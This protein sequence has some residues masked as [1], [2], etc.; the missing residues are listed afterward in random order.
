MQGFSTKL[1]DT[2]FWYNTT[3]NRFTPLEDGWGRFE[4]DNSK[5]SN[6]TY[7]NA[8]VRAIQFEKILKKNKQYKA[9]IEFRNV[10]MD[11]N[12]GTS[13]FCLAGNNANEIFKEN[14]SLYRNKIKQLKQTAIVTTKDNIEIAT[15]T[16]L[17]RSF[18]SVTARKQSIFRM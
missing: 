5:G 14:V 13:Y 6:V 18:L 1:E 7:A 16:L 10:E 4:V 3:A 12:D 15:T 8:F 2:N 11:D 17:L 9:L